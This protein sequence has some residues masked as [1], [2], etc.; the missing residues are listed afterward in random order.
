M[1]SLEIS[2]LSF[3][4]SYKI[5]IR[6]LFEGSFTD[7]FP[8]DII[9]RFFNTKSEI[10]LLS[11]ATYNSR[12]SIRRNNGKTNVITANEDT[13]SVYHTNCTENITTK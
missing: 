10:V 9:L 3:R 12:F 8:W 11:S 7:L 5:V 4:K 6:S 2:G 1:N 13:T